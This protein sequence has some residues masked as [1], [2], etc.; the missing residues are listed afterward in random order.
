MNGRVATLQG[1]YTRE[2]TAKILGITERTVIRWQGTKLTPLRD[3]D[4]PTQRRVFYDRTQVDSLARR[5]RRRGEV[6][7]PAPVNGLVEQIPGRKVSRGFAMLRQGHTKAE[8]CE[9]LELSL[10]QVELLEERLVAWNAERS[11]KDQPRGPRTPTTSSVR[12]DAHGARLIYDEDP[13]MLAWQNKIDEESRWTEE[14]APS[15]E[16]KDDDE[17]GPPSSRAA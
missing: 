9:E 8:V 5:L 12:S 6:P 4:D 1:T 2:E 14:E 10:E 16:K 13:E 7:L 11:V 15:S 17:E 3:P